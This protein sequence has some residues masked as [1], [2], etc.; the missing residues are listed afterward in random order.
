ME[1]LSG[2][3]DPK[4]SQFEV[5]EIISCIPKLNELTSKKI[6]TNFN[7]IRNFFVNSDIKSLILDYPVLTSNFTPEPEKLEFYFKLYMNMSKDELLSLAT[8]FPLLMTASV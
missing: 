2:I 4:L 6:I 7:R 3:L 5:N 8:N 1:T